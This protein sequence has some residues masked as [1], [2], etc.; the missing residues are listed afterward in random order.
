MAEPGSS[1]EHL[2]PKSTYRHRPHASSGNAPRHDPLDRREHIFKDTGDYTT[3]IGILAQLVSAGELVCH[4]FCFMPTHYHVFG[5]FR[6]VS[7]AIHT[8]N[9]R[10]AVAYNRRYRRRGH[11]DSPFS[12]TEVQTLPHARY[13]GRYIALNP[14]DHERWPYAS[15][16]GLIGTGAAFSFVDQWPIVEA[17][18]TIDAFRE[19]VDEG[20][21]GEESEPL[22]HDEAALLL[23]DPLEAVA[24]VEGDRG[25]V[26][27][28][29]QRH[30][31]VTGRSRG[32]DEGIEQL[33]AEAVP[34]ARG[35]DGDG[36][37]G[38]AL[39]DEPVAGLRRVEQ[40]QPRRPDAV[41]GL[42]GD[43]GEV[44]GAPPV[45]D[46]ARERDVGLERVD[47]PGVG[48]RKHRAHERDVGRG[49]LAD[50]V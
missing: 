25:G 21:E 39:V 29:T 45:V 37:L 38:G 48:V 18:G 4:M 47:P 15:Y 12:R 43:H 14:P 23:A 40:A 7:V 42:V 24:L 27:L 46:V 36:E 22:A 35:D 34:P 5:T 1:L 20:Q 44:A 49:S 26:G 11:V 50:H 16:P 28:D 19:F 2:V 10:Y 3:G 13:L 41:A 30:R 31:S 33:L 8:L 6:D 9:R 17:F 32:D